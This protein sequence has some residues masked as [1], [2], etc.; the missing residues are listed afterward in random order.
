M[1]MRHKR[2]QLFI[3]KNTIAITIPA[4]G[5]FL[6][7]IFMLARYPV[8]EQIRCNKI[9][10]V[11]KLSTR[12]DNLYK[13]DMR[14]V[15]YTAHDLYY[16][17]F[18]YF[19][20]DNKKGSYYYSLMDNELVIY[21]IKTK[22]PKIYIEEQRLKGHIIKDSVSAE[23]IMGQLATV[24]HMDTSMIKNYA[25]V[26]VISEPD[27]PHAFITMI[28]AIFFIPIVL[29]ILIFL[30][31]ILVWIQPVLHSQVRQLVVYG[32]PSAVMEEL[33]KELCYHMLYHKSNIYITDSFM[34]I[35]H[36]TKTEVVRLDDV[37]YLSKNLIEGVGLRNKKQIYR[38][39]MSNPDKL[40]CEI[41]FTSERVID[42][43]VRYIYGANT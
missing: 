33:N 4:I 26:Y 20:N 19:V 43:V 6:L 12:L 22:Q 21:L 2:F 39:T 16:T 31:T 9:E 5:V 34:I 11:E 29:C 15:E 36:L 41:D 8:F 42:E 14:N 30:Y 24:N 23:Y 7:L 18:D 17:G 38:L 40:F 28:Y 13:N 27:Y 25:S 37:K 1:N 32:D 3:F 35:A 10:D